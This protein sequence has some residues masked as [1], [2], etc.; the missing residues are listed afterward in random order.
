MRVASP[1]A[2]MCVAMVALFLTVGL[3]TSH[4][5]T[6]QLHSMEPLLSVKND[7]KEA[8]HLQVGAWGNQDSVGNLGVQTEIQT[9]SYNVSDSAEDAFWLG[10]ILTDGAFIQFGY[11][12]LSPGYYCLAAHVTANTTVCA[13]VDD[14]VNVGDARW[15]WAYFPNAQKVDEWYYGF[16]L[17]NSAGLNGTWHLYSILPG[18]SGDWSFEMDGV[19]IYST[20]F[21]ST[22]SSSPAHIVAE[23]ASGPDQ[24]Q[25]GPVEFRNLAYLGA[26]GNWH[27]TASLT[28]IVGCGEGDAPCNVAIPYG[29]AAVGA[30]D[31]VAGSNVPP[32]SPSQPIWSRQAACSMYM[33]L[34][35]NGGTGP[36]PL[37]VN[38]T[39]ATH[40][41]H[42]NVR[43]DWWFG[44]GSYAPGN[45][46][47][48]VTYS[49]PGNYTLLVRGLD[50]VGCLS[51]ASGRVLVMQPGLSG[52]S[53]TYASSVPG[54]PFVLI[55]ALMTSVAPITMLRRNQP[56]GSTRL[57]P[58]NCNEDLRLCSASEGI[59]S[60]SPK[61]LEMFHNLISELLYT[62]KLSA[63][64]K[65]GNEVL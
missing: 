5:F 32:P 63:P 53:L 3:V 12:I 16:G 34:T 38:L 13:G 56:P 61:F 37:R 9:H 41:S 1:S 42:G 40:A 21:P 59:G 39:A 45:S 44:N 27:G 30:N 54:M 43:T 65:A 31:V 57:E 35:D 25:L 36:A 4:P 20:I 55:V 50:S 52:S 7:S 19:T 10:S 49:N 14:T 11:L 62:L 17:S 15:F 8:W 60:V 6:H 22:P 51:E 24:Q 46:N 33:T 47:R 28:P 2:L 58:V 18:E 64:F 26:D 29:V 48:T 23:K